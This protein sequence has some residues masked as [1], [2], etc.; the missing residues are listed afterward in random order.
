MLR[1]G[2]NIATAHAAFGPVRCSQSPLMAGPFRRARGA[3]CEW[4][5]LVKWRPGI[6]HHKS[7]IDATRTLGPNP[8]HSTTFDVLRSLLGAKHMAC[9]SAARQIWRV[10]RSPSSKSATCVD[11]AP[12]KAISRQTKKDVA[13]SAPMRGDDAK[14]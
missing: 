4:L 1:Y 6:R 2:V 8:R 11:G 12:P 14:K 13:P 3:A 9:L 10:G 5:A 7:D